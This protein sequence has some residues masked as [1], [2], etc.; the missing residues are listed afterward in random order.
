VL[1]GR[2]SSPST[3][4]DARILGIDLIAQNVVVVARAP[5]GEPD[6]RPRT[7]RVAAKALRN[8]LLRQL[9]HGRALV[10]IREGEVVSLCPAP[11]PLDG[12]RAA[13][14]AHTAAAA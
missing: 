8:E 5:V 2:S 1:A 10:G 14:G 4:R 11:T 6:Q 13:E 12:R 9:D 3:K 7:L